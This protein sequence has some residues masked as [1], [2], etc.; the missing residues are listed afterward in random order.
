VRIL[1]VSDFPVLNTGYATVSRH[2]VP[3]LVHEHEVYYLPI[4]GPEHGAFSPE[5]FGA[6]VLPT[7]TSPNDVAY[8]YFKKDC[9]VV[10]ILKDPYVFNGVENLPVF[11]VF[12]SPVAEE[13][14]SPQ[15]KTITQTAMYIWIPSSWGIRVAK[16]SGIH[17]QRLR[18]VP[19]GVSDAYKV[20]DE[21]DKCKAR[22]GFPDVDV[23][24]SMVSVNRGRKFIP[25]QLEGVRKFIENNPDLKVGV[26]LHTNPQPDNYSLHGGWN[27]PT[28]LD[29]YGLADVV[30]FPDPYIYRIGFSEKQ[31]CEL[32][33]ATD[34]LL[35]ATTEGYGLPIIESQ[36]CGTPVV[37]VNH[38]NG[39]EINFFGLNAEVGAFYYTIV[40]TKFAVPDSDSVAEQIEK[41]LKISE[42]DRKSVA[43]FVRRTYD[44]DVVYKGYVR[45]E[46]DKI[47]SELDPRKI[48][49]VI[50]R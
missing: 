4:A 17:Y 31:M 1:Y 41:A 9:D 46:L 7:V 37:T 35:N 14:L 12:Y 25:N 2:L 28:V 22:F 15:Y 40:G 19:H 3:R 16:E 6:E 8:W 48:V 47:E 10:I 20:L 33:N 50:A 38:G 27:L 11:T 39:P 42:K 30:R 29:L 49:E 24:I 36:A 45:K 13:P 34:V 5:I 26:Y 21:P 43:D 18:Y 44:W 32:Y 23:L